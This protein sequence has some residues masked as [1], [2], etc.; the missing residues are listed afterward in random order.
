MHKNRLWQNGSP[1]RIR[2]AIGGQTLPGARPGVGKQ[3]E[4]V[5]TSSGWAGSRGGYAATDAAPAAGA[6]V[7]A[8]KQ[9]AATEQVNGNM[10]QIS[11]MVQQSAVSAEESAKACQDLS[12]L[13]F[14]LRR[15][16]SKFKVDGG[17]GARRRGGKHAPLYE[18]AALGAPMFNSVN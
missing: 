8:F 17:H 2:R 4:I 13:A 5:G 18:A 7:K 6:G 12:S 10:E 1:L 3:G 14:D 11:R 16:V 15:A 9:A